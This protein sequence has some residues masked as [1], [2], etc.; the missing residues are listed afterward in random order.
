[1]MKRFLMALIGFLALSLGPG[2]RAYSAEIQNVDP[3]FWWVGMKNP[4]LQI[5]IHG[6]KIAEN[7]VSVNYPGVSVK[8][9][10]KTENPNYLFLY[11]N[12][13]P[14]AKPGTMDITFSGKDGKTV[15]PFELKE[16]NKK[17]GALGFT[18]EDVL[19]L[20]TPDRFADGNPDN[21]TLE[22]A[23]ADRSRS[24]GRHGGDIKGVVDHLDYI[25]DLGI[26]AIWLNPVQKNAAG[27]YHGYAITD[28]YDID[29][30]FGTMEEY[31]DFVDKAHARGMKVVMDMIFN[32]CG[33]GHWWMNDLPTGD[34]LNFNNKFVATS[35]NKWTAVDPHAAPSERKLFV[36][37]WFNSGMPDLNQKNPLVADYLIQNGIWWIEYARI[38]GI[39]QDTHPYMDPLFG[40]RWCKET[41]EEYPDFNIT[42]ETWYPLGSGFPAWWQQGS[43]LNKEWDSHLKTVMDFNLVFLAGDAFTDPNNSADGAATGL[44]NIYVSLANDRLYADTDNILVFLDNHDLGRFSRKEDVGL[45]RYKQGIAFLL[46]TRGI[47]QVYYGTELLFK[48]TKQQGDGA[49]RIDM[50]GGFPGDERSVFT[51]EGR[52]AEENEAYDYMQKILQWR[53][54]SDAVQHGKLIQYAPLREHGDCY[55]YARIKD[56]KT[57]L[58]VLNGSDRDADISMSRYSDVIGSY[59]SG[60]DVITGEVYNLTNKLHVPARGTYIFDLFTPEF[61]VAPGSDIPAPPYAAFSEGLIDK[62]QP[63]GWLKEIL[64]R[65][66][67]GLTGHPEAMAYPYN[68]VLWAGKLERDSES[69]G[70]DW[71]RFEQTAYYLDGLT[72]LGFLLDDKKFLDLWQ[73][74]IDYVLNNPLPFKK[75]TPP[76][77]AT[78]Q[79]GRG[80]RQGG[81][82]G[83]QGG[84]GGFQNMTPEQRQQMLQNMPAEQRQ[85]FEQMMQQQGQN[86]QNGQNAQ[87]QG[88]DQNP[89]VQGQRPQRQGGDDFNA[90][91]SADPRA[92]QRAADQQ[93]RRAKQQRIAAADRPEG[94][95]GPETGSMA[96]PWAVFFRAVKAYYE[97]TGDPRIPQALE[98][99][100]LSYTVEELGMNR[101]VVN[102]EGMLWT[103]SITRNP[104]L[105]EAAVKAWDENASDMTQE[106]A[107]NDEPFR[108]HGVT[109]NELLKI[110]LILY[111]YTGDEK[112]L[113]AA[114]HAEAKMEGPNMLIDGINS[115]SESLAG[116]DPLASH[117][118]CDVSDYTWTMGYYLMTTGDGQ[119][120]DRIEKGIFNGGLG[121]I[122]KD[123]KSMQYFSCPNQ[124][125]AT[126]NS[127]H[128]GFKHG[129]TWMAYRPIHETECCIGN[130][131]RYMPN[132]VARM[133]LR[134]KKGHPVAALYGPSSVEYDLGGGVTVQIEEKTNYP[135]EEQIRFEFHFFENG[136]PSSKKYNMDFTYRIPEWCKA[137]KAGFKTVS[138]AW[139]SGDSFTVK[140]PMQIEVVN[141][142]VA[143]ASIQ[144][145]PIVYTYAVPANVVEDPQIYS[146]MA[147]KVSANP[148]FKNWSMTPAGK[149]NYAL[150]TNRLSGLKVQKTGAKGFPFDPDNVPLKIRVPVVGVQGWTLQED[151]YT[152]ALPEKV[153]AEGGIQYIDLVPYGSTT[154]RLTIFPTIEK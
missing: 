140:L 67:D 97:A 33:S 146:N 52:T 19:Y 101:F 82:G 132:Y 89:Q 22:G 111:S 108:M 150:V 18:T 47:P 45:N 16:R 12:I 90:Q 118:T 143:G 123:F 41:M 141:N 76:D 72:R 94:R 102:V 8:D 137:E 53:K 10:V 51:R 149:W 113:K 24:G 107:L 36:D 127:N 6:P 79:Q 144:R 4:T 88:Q 23:R 13:G 115:S 37:G 154:L 98:K 34:W 59:T 148:D 130:L 11:L 77:P 60:K 7:E 110:P 109:M 64:E 83:G 49:I 2:F 104:A 131:H 62:I 117:E 136:K 31:I 43:V 119:W 86:A 103:Y 114:L 42:G 65:Q 95:L 29:P 106:S 32:H 126:G 84:P 135:F 21:N 48:A 70:A 133:W 139:K 17:P 152:P 1:M 92:Q 134:D 145:G 85:R 28:Y 142:P 91:V 9:I 99:N 66:R 27:T 80:G 55:V 46:T 44:F 38:D 57:V 78:Q 69:R 87:R 54:T 96:W 129:L 25:D 61:T 81:F 122:T 50:P 30:R 147:G 112:Y 58:V 71:W 138:K 3:P 26:T 73:E 75:G 120:A 14:S 20:I 93:A 15:R 124:V 153:E 100:Y 63:Q 121:S 105:L 151:R 74:N 125:I 68:S 39:R 35:H 56:D 116:N 5:L 128:N 40:S